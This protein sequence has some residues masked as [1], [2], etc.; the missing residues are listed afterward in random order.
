M[1]IEFEKWHGTKNDFIVIWIRNHEKELL[2]PT[3]QRLASQICNRDGSGVGGDGILVLVSK[4]HKDPHAEELVIINSDGSLASNCGNG[5]RCAASSARSK[6]HLEGI[7]DF[8]GITFNVQGR[9]INCRF[10]GNSSNPFVAVT[11]PAPSIGINNQWHQDTKDR[12]TIL[13]RNLPALKGELETVDIGNPHIVFFVDQ[14]TQGLARE[15]GPTLQ[16]CRDG[17]GMNVHIA[18]SMEISEV[19]Q[20][21]ARRDVGESIGELLQVFPWERGVGLTQ[22]CGTG[23]CAVGVSTLAS[24]F[25]ERSEWVGIQ[26]P[27]GRVY[28]KQSHQDDEIILAGPTMFVFSGR[29]EI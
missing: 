6:A 27:G 25:V 2:I 22:A 1:F 16:A 5:L 11:M 28:V 10:L 24:G 12:A 19:D 8:D 9:K 15:C 23:A 17:D 7:V 18:S 29:L 14:A 20:K 21:L 13:Q 26:M 3:F 4:S